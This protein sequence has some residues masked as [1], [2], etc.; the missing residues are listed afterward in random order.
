[1]PRARFVNQTMAPATRKDQGL[2]D[3]LRVDSR[4]AAGRTLTF[5]N[6]ATLLISEST[7]LISESELPLDDCSRYKYPTNSLSSDY[8]E[9]RADWTE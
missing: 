6:S 9:E 1:M 4:L 5:S 2:Q 7:Q 3:D 8:F